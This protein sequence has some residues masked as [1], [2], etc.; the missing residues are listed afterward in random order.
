MLT[1]I[2]N[3]L[4]KEVSGLHA[5][6]QG[7]YNIRSNGEAVERRSTTNIEIL[8]FND[9]TGIEIK[10]KP[11]TKGESVHIPVIISKAGLNDVV[12]N[13]FYVG[14]GA[15]VI[16][17][18]G[19]GIHTSKN[20]KTSHNGI[21]RFF[22]GKNAKVK[23]IEK[24]LGKGASQNKELSP[25][26]EITLDDGA[27]FI[28][29]SM[30]LGGVNNSVRTTLATIKDNAK[31]Q[32]RESLLTN[33]QDKVETNFCANMVGNGARA[34]IVSRAVARGK[35]LQKYSSVLNGKA[36]CFG[37]TECDAIIMEEAKVFA[38]PKVFAEHTDASLVHEAAIG[39]IA[40]EEIIKLMTLGL[41]EE[42]A[43]ETIIKGFLK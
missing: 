1:N 36:E 32:I 40:G 37:H 7:A 6:P 33:E 11:Y 43:Q 34:H 21:H 18:A 41:S 42:E 27:E 31:L 14:E 26:T 30:Q 23:Y 25:V 19:C 9:K 28:M 8:P 10:I 16:I 15:E 20:T 22:I 12:R 3:E 17:V 24:H 38:E 35:S 29:E 13:D 2:E 4:L 39:K 5:V